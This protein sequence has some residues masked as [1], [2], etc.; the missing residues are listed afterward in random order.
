MPERASELERFGLRAPG[1]WFRV[2]EHSLNQPK[3]SRFQDRLDAFMFTVQQ[4]GV[5]VR[6]YD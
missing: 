3:R 5:E 2:Q 6:D 1:S 4:R